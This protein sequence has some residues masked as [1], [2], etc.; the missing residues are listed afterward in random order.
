[1]RMSEAHEGAPVALPAGAIAAQIRP[2]LLQCG[3]CGRQRVFALPEGATP[4]A[5]ARQSGLARSS[6]ARCGVV[7]Q[8]EARSLPPS[9]YI[10]NAGT[11]HICERAAQVYA[12]QRDRATAAPAES[13]GDEG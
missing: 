1:M 7:T 3:R 12:Q 11:V 4:A 9:A 6:C 13:G 2:A 10:S 8:H 5:W